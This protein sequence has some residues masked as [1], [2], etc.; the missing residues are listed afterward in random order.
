MICPPKGVVAMLAQ[1]VGLHKCDPD[2][3]DYLRICA[4][5]PH[6]QFHRHTNFSPHAA[7]FYAFAQVNGVRI[8]AYR[9]HVQMRPPTNLF[10][11]NQNFGGCPKSFR[12]SP[13]LTRQPLEDTRTHK[14]GVVY[15]IWWR[16][17]LRH[18]TFQ[19]TCFQFHFIGHITSWLHFWGFWKPD[20]VIFA[21]IVDL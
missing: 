17:A 18:P 6:V 21:R 13:M 10:S 1:V 19:S 5:Q 15:L 11:Q 12:Q 3:T 8:W 9:L 2:Q 4:N 20:A 16:P 14:L 7:L